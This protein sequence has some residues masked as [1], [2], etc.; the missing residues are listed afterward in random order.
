MG[1]ANKGWRSVE[2]REDGP[3]RRPRPEPVSRSSL[4]RTLAFAV[5]AVG[6]HLL[7]LPLLGEQVS[8]LGKGAKKEAPFRVATNLSP[9]TLKA[10]KESSKQLRAQSRAPDAKPPPPP[11]EKKQEKLDGQVVDVPPS[12]DDRAPDHAKYLSQH[13]TRA[14]KET[15]SRHQSQ[16]YRN[17]MNE[18][19]TTQRGNVQGPIPPQESKALEIGPDRPSD[20][21]KVAGA[22]QAPALEI[23]RVEERERLALQREAADGKLGNHPGSERIDGNSDRLKLSLADPGDRPSER[24]SAPTQGPPTLQLLPQLGV[25]ARLSGAPA[26]DHL[27]D[28][29]E[30]EGTF[31][32]SREFKYASF[33]NRLKREV[34]ENWRPLDEYRRR[35]P[36]GNIYGYRSRTTVLSVTLDA[37]GKVKTVQV[38]RSS[39][40][41]FLDQEAMAAFQRAQQFP[42]PPHGLVGTDGQVTFPFGFHIDFGGG[43]RAPF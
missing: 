14:E 32:N 9:A 41:D 34:S 33:F 11:D 29:E 15:R 43:L 5:V 30:G 28:L 12:P 35:D 17:A 10:L 1:N 19:T 13:N 23:P 8:L 20:K 4:R 42:N 39:G 37:G 6:L 21:K 40:L 7:L 3:L 26:N 16:F 38:S 36:T 31:L 24:G 25:L 18:P 2:R 22:G 27:E